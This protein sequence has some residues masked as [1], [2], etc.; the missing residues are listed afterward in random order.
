MR[1][2]LYDLQ[3]IKLNYLGA[4]VN[5][6]IENGCLYMVNTLTNR[7]IIVKGETF[8]LQKLLGLLLDGVADEVL[9]NCLSEMGSAGQYEVWLREGLIE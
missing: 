2:V 1:Q 6:H 8:R 4:Y 3:N 9:I 7:Q 5:T